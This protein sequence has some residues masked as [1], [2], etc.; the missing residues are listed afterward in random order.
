MNAFDYGSVFSSENLVTFMKPINS[1]WVAL[2]PG[3]QIF[4]G[5]IFAAVLWPFRTIFLNQERGWLKLWMLFIG[6]S[7]LATFGPAIGS[8]D[9]MIYTTIPISKQ[10]LFLPELVIQSFLLSFLL[11]Y[12]YKKPKRV[13][14]II[15]ILLACIIIL[16]SIAGFLSLI[17]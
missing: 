14:T 4:R 6:L 1:P 13:F 2:G 16:L 3:L 12:W 8:I 10:L 15:S 17:M 5:A 9:G 7:I 11:F